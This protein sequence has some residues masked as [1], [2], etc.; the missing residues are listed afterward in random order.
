MKTLLVLLALTFATE[1]SG[2]QFRGGFGRT[3]SHSAMT[4]QYRPAPMYRGHRQFYQPGLYGY[5]YGPGYYSSA[6]HPSPIFQ[7][8]FNDPYYYW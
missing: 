4:R 8:S 7:Q 2:Q 1:A 5:A 6:F 3:G